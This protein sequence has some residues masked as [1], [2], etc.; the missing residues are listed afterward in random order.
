MNISYRI[1]PSISNEALNQLF[2]AAWPKYQERDFS[3]ILSRSLTFMCAYQAESLIGFIYLAWDGG[4][5]AFILDPTVHPDVRRYGVGTQLVKR[6]IAIARQKSIKWIHVDYE[7]HLRDF[8][9]QC[10]FR[11]TEAGLIAL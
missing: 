10:G 3:P 1:E 6:V 8:Y 2:F 4:S 7:P 5:H 9:Q 11:P